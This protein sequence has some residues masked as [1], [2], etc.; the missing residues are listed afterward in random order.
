[1]PR[2]Y[3]LR[4]RAERQAATRQRIVAA[5]VA[6]HE[7]IAAMAGMVRCLASGGSEQLVAP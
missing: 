3:E 2:K 7:E 1:M 6:L 4:Q 5:T